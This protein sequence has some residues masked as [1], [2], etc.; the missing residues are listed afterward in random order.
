MLEPIRIEPDAFYDDGSL[1]QAIEVSPASLASARTSGLLRFTRTGRRT[2][3]KGS[4]VLA[5]LEATAADARPGA[6]VRQEGG[7]R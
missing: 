1:Y 6:A 4:W 7:A 3:Y 5:W 2:F